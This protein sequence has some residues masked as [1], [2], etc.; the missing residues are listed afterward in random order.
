MGIISPPKELL[1]ELKLI[2]DIKVPNMTWHIG[3]HSEEKQVSPDIQKSWLGA[4]ILIGRNKGYQTSP[5]L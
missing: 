2:I 4:E 3:R 1:A 5:T